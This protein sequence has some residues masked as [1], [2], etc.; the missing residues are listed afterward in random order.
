[1]R[2]RKAMV[3]LRISRNIASARSDDVANVDI[4]SDQ[5]LRAT[6]SA[7]GCAS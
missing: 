5:S 4:A 6:S 1:V 3:I 7:N 2:Q